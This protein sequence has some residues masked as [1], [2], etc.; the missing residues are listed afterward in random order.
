VTNYAAVPPQADDLWCPLHQKRENK[1]IA[2]KGS[3]P[4]SAHGVENAQTLREG[5]SE[6]KE[7]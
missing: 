3:V 6:V 2:C 5:T 1:N 7:V 4:M